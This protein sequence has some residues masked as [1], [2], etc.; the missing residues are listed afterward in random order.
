MVAGVTVPV[1]EDCTIAFS[2]SYAD[3]TGDVA[4]RTL[5]FERVR[6]KIVYDRR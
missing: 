5:S 1:A 4:G 6:G 2:G 3:Y